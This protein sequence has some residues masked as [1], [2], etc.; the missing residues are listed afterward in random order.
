[1]SRSRTPIKVLNGTSTPTGGWRRRYNFQPR[2]AKHPHLKKYDGH[3]A[4]S[5]S[6]AVGKGTFAPPHQWHLYAKT[7]GL[8]KQKLQR[9]GNSGGRKLE[10]STERIERKDAN[11]ALNLADDC[12]ANTRGGSE[13]GAQHSLRRQPTRRRGQRRALPSRRTSCLAR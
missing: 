5:M 11:W 3:T 9:A 13:G 10:R 6:L 12:D 7:E 2:G 1:M 4:T 8:K